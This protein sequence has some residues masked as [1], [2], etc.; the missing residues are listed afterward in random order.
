MTACVNCGSEH[1]ESEMEPEHTAKG[2]RL[3]CVACYV[4]VFL[5]QGL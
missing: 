2:P 3:W 5:K 1:P 4:R